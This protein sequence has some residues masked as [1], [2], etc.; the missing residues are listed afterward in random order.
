MGNKV[1]FK[2]TRKIIRDLS[3]SNIKYDSFI[4]WFD[5]PIRQL[6]IL[7]LNPGIQ[8]FEAI[9]T[10]KYRGYLSPIQFPGV[11]IMS[12]VDFD[13]SFDGKRLEVNCF[14]DSLVQD[15]QGSKIL[16]SLI[17]KLLPKIQSSNILT[18]N[19]DNYLINEATLNICFDLPNW[20]PFN[21]NTL[22]KQGSIAIGNS[23]DKDLND[24]LD[25]IIETYKK[26]NN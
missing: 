15:F 13:T 14:D 26:L 16:I 24:L 8:S 2:A 25:R 20:F 17:S 1:N 10:N 12:R 18:I 19:N 5:K 11:S 6:E 3:D 4:Q 22:E 7:K 21:R 9:G 23:I